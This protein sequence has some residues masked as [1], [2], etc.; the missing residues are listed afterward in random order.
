VVATRDRP[1][2]LARCLQSLAAQRTIR[3]LE[4]IVVDNHPDSGVTA[5]VAGR[6]PGVR[7][8]EERRGGLS[9]ARNAGILAAT[10]DIIATTDDDAVCA[11]DWVERLVAAFARE[12]V[13]IVTGNVLPIELETEAQRLFEAY[14]GL[15]R[16]FTRFIVDREWFRRLRRAVPTWELGCTANAAFR[17]SIFADPEIGLI[18]EALGAGTPTGCSE[19][20]YVFYR[21]LKAGYSIVYE[22]DALV[23]HR[24]RDTMQALRHQ[25]YSYSKGHVAYHLTTWLDEG[26][27]R[28]LVR[29]VYEL[30]RTYARRSY[31]LLRGWSEYPLS[32]IALEMAGNVAGP[33]ALLRSRRR[34]KRLGR[35][36]FRPRAAATTRQAEST[37]DTADVL[38]V[39]SQGP[40][41]APR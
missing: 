5:P 16:G 17:S 21:A 30:P 9:Y 6:F 14:G 1:D 29:L 28:G 2:D 3:R 11:S 31:H 39:E 10:G 25:I 35:T 15:G 13:A 34:V 33:W 37:R 41:M 32:F 19:D 27:W 23:W 26:D 8:V 4:V 18:D 22:P 36:I 7:V 38:Y 12:D 24:H 20:T 40:E